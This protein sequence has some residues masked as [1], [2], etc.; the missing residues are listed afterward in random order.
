MGCCVVLGGK[1]ALTHVTAQRNLEDSMSSDRGRARRGGR[2]AQFRLHTVQCSSQIH[3]DRR[4]MVVAR[5]WGEGS[6]GSCHLM[7]AEC[8]LGRRKKVP[9]TDGGK[10]TECP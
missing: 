9:E 7:R 1:E 3:R 4:G 2:G 8:Q 5:G 6:V 10:R